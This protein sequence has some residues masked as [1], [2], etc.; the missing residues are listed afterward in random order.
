MDANQ[1][2]VLVY[3]RYKYGLLNSIYTGLLSHKTFNAVTTNNK[4]CVLNDLK[5][6]S[7]SDHE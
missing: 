2:F 3:Y 5:H 1:V 7:K 6:H 4:T